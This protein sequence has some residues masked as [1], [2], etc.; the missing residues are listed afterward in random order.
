MQFN[1]EAVS[2]QRLYRLIADKIADKIRA[3][4]FPVG[5]RLP[6]ERDLAEVLSVSRSSVREALIALELSGYVEVRLGSGVYVTM[7]RQSAASASSSGGEGVAGASIAAAD[8]GPFE[9]LEARLLIEPEVAALAAQHA[10]EPQLEQLR[11]ERDDLADGATPSH[12]DRRFH[13]VI[14]A[15]CGNSAL[16]A[17]VLSLRDLSEANPVYQRLDEHLVG[18]NAWNA[19]RTEHVRIANAIL[20]RDPIR[21]RH[22]MYAHLIAIMARLRENFAEELPAPARRASRKSGLKEPRSALAKEGRKKRES[23]A[24]LAAADTLKPVLAR[25]SRRR[26]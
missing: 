25:A 15:S 12:L 24:N 5:S 26:S 13:S 14:A 19:A 20:D 7:P 10:S 1:L 2:A 16:E 4:D 23:G 11:K 18:R 22:E 3:G 21:A 8:I 9:L 6:G 17:M